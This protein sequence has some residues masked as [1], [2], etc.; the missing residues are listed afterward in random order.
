MFVCVCY[1]RGGGRERSREGARERGGGSDGR[2]VERER[3]REG[4]REGGREGGRE[5]EN[6]A[7]PINFVGRRW[8]VSFEMPQMEHSLFVIQL[9]LTESTLSLSE[10]EVPTSSSVS[11]TKMGNL[12]SRNQP[13]SVPFQS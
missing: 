1:E 5:R 7:L 10:G 13:V 6:C 11:S 3:G 8:P 9:V 12:D 4:E 2:R